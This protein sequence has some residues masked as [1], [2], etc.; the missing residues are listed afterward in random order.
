M[1]K[2]SH[3]FEKKGNNDYLL[4]NKNERKN[5]TKNNLLKE[6]NKI[7]I[8]KNKIVGGRWLGKESKF[9]CWFCSQTRNYLFCILRV[10][11]GLGT[12]RAFHQWN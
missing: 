9:V 6:K 12:L 2:Q 11:C 5:E 8:F 1:K 4:I 3:G 7:I 10:M